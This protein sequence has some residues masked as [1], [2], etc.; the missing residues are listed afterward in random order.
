MGRAK[1][2]AK[3]VG[4]VD[5]SRIDVAA[6][7]NTGKQPTSKDKAGQEQT[8]SNQWRQAGHSV[9]AAEDRGSQVPRDSVRVG[10]WA[11]G[12]RAALPSVRIRW[13]LQ[14]A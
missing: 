4:R 9:A 11:A 2:R 5:P 1:T 13:A 8:G 6:N 14:W 3:V 12:R 7:A 10:A